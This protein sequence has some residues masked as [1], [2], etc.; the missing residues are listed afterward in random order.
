MSRES[1]P[2]GA[3]PRICAQ[4]IMY[5]TIRSFFSMKRGYCA[6]RQSIFTEMTLSCC[7]RTSGNRVR[8]AMNRH[9]LAM[10]A[11]SRMMQSMRRCQT[12]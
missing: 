4:I 11:D 2:V 7:V 10:L 12:Q 3:M 5:A 9:P 6:A 8:V 1:N